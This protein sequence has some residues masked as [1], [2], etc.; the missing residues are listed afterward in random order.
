MRRITVY[1][2][3][4]IMAHMPSGQVKFLTWLG[5]IKL[6]WWAIR[7]KVEVEIKESGK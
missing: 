5:F 4:E 3:E 7:N 1:C 2:G 6:A